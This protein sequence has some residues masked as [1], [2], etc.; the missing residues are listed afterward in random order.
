MKTIIIMILVSSLVISI[1]LEFLLGKQRQG[2]K[3]Q[4]CY[5]QYQQTHSCKKLITCFE[6]MEIR[7]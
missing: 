5:E 1:T 6:T 3:L 2:R 7:K 4:V